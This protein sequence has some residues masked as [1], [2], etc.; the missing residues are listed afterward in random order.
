MYP[1]LYIQVAPSEFIRYQDG[2]VQDA[3]SKFDVLTVNTATAVSSEGEVTLNSADPFESVNIDFKGYTDGDLEKIAKLVLELRQV[4]GALEN[5]FV[6][7]EE[8]RPGFSDQTS[9]EDAKEWV[10]KNGWGHHACCTAKIGADSD[11]D[12]V[13]DGQFRVRKVKNLRVVDASAFPAQPGFFP[14]VPIMM[15]AEKAADDIIAEHSYTV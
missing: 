2:W 6:F 10:R 12:A 13:L 7:V 5:V 1:D 11:S 8:L 9:L 15:L 4:V 3:F 14:T